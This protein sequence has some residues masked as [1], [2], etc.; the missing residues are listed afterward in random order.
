MGVMVQNKV[1]HFYRPWSS[2]IANAVSNRGPMH[3]KV[4]I[5]TTSYNLLAQYLLL[6]LQVYFSYSA[7]LQNGRAS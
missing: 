7:P 3:L 5:R 1:V 2:K 4:T 6:L